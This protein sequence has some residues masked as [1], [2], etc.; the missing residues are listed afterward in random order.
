MSDGFGIICANTGHE[1]VG[2]RYLVE[3]LRASSRTRK[4]S[5]TLNQIIPQ[6]RQGAT[7]MAFAHWVMAHTAAQLCFA[8]IQGQLSFGL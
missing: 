6:D 1:E 7:I 4:F 2:S 5:G 8:D 3:P